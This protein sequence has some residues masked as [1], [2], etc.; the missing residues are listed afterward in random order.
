MI[1]ELNENEYYK[2]RPLIKGRADLNVS[3]NAIIDGTNRGKIW[4]DHLSDP[5]TAIVWAIGSMYF[6]IGRSNNEAFD[7]IGRAHV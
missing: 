5:E 4:V 7:K 6:I 2:I 1:Y 3:I